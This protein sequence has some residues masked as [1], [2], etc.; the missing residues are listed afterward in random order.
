MSHSRTYYPL[1]ASHT[2]C[3]YTTPRK[4]TLERVIKKN[5][6]TELF[7]PPPILWGRGAACLIKD[8]EWL[9]LPGAGWQVLESVF[10]QHAN[11]NLPQKA[12]IWAK[13]ADQEKAK[14]YIHI[15]VLY[16]YIYFRT[17]THTY[18]QTP[19]LKISAPVNCSDWTEYGEHASNK[20]QMGCNA[21]LPLSSASCV[22][23]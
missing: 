6:K 8:S 9:V 16:T 3:K 18:Q 20:N 1:P 7:S 12:W 5:I 10:S 17:Y 4:T 14:I 15:Y 13:N 11:Y 2:P 21:S 22:L 23:V 19:S